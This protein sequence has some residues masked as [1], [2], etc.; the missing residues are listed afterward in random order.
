MHP[1]FDDHQKSKQQKKCV[2]LFSVSFFF[3]SRKACA[4]AIY[5]VCIGEFES[6]IHCLDRMA[7]KKKSIR[8]PQF[9]S[10]SRSGGLAQ[11]MSKSINTKKKVSRS[12]A[13]KIQIR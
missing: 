1:A 8:K 10:A 11:G 4:P 6:I 7:N 12:L 9:A 13:F 3:P 5:L 2:P